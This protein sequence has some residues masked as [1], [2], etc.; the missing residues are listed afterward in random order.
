MLIFYVHHMAYTA[1][2]TT[3]I[4]WNLQRMLD[5]S[6]NYLLVFQQL[7][8]QYNKSNITHVLE[9]DKTKS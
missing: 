5:L 8:P 2:E 4:L 1:Y 3:S 9:Q 6:C 7:E